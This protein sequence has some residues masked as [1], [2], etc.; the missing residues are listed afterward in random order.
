MLGIGLRLSGVTVD[1]EK[2]NLATVENPTM[3]GLGLQFRGKVSSHVGLEL[4]MDVLYGQTDDMR[5]TTVPVT[6]SALYYFIPRGTFKLYGLLGGG[7]HFTKLEYNFG[8]RHDLAEIA[9]QAG[10][11]I[12]LRLSRDF[13]INADMRFIGLYKNI[14]EMSS[15]QSKCISHTGM[16][17]GGITDTDRFNVGAQ[18]MAGANFYF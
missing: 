1:G 2:L 12:E 3:G 4:A 5:Q 7:V 14:D 6:L 11:G 15:I 18:F 17:C 8:M 9:G 13:S 16:Q 10:G